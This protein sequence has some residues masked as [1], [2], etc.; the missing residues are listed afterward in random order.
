MYIRYYLSLAVFAV[1]YFIGLFIHPLMYLQYPLNGGIF[2][3]WGN[4]SEKDKFECW[5]GDE[6][7]RKRYGLTRKSNIFKKYFVSYVWMAIR[8]PHW[9]LKQ[10]LFP[11]K[12]KITLYKIIYF[13]GDG[14]PMTWRR[15]GVHGRLK[16]IVQ[17]ERGRKAPRWSKGVLLPDGRTKYSQYGAGN[18]RY[19]FKSRTA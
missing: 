12:G 10:L 17:D 9:R 18:G 2:W 7:W 11:L 1:A 14:S 3:L 6:N 5:H 8:N 16:I 19:H 15:K 4:S 13:D